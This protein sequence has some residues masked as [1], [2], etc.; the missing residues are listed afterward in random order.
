M[1]RFI[2]FALAFLLLP[3]ITRAQCCSAG[4]PLSSD[5]LQESV[6]KNSLRI[7]T[8]FKHSYSDQYFTEDHPIHVP[9][10]RFSRFNFSSF[11]L[12]CG[13]SNRLNIQGE[14]GYFFDKSQSIDIQGITLLSAHGIGDLGLSMKYRIIKETRKK[15]QINATVGVKFPVG[16][17]DQEMDGITLPLSLQPSNGAMKYTGSLFYAYQKPNSNYRFHWI[18]T[19][20]ISSVIESKN[21]YYKYG[22]LLTNS[23]SA[24]YT[25]HRKINMGIQTRYEYRNHD[26]REKEQIVASTGSHVVYAAPFFQFILPWKMEAFLQADYPVYKKVNGSQLTNKYSLNFSL[27]RRISFQRAEKER[28]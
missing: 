16:A 10:I 27:A 13:I 2:F 22:N 4:N 23:I 17:F 21:F 11:Q 24:S 8:Q 28:P 14:L 25:F 7:I 12:V 9:Q 20:E 1:K 15:H 6:Q 26:T 18:S 5:L 19:M 3:C